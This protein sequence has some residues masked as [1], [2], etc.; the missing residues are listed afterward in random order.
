MSFPNF[1]HEDIL[2]YL[3]KSDKAGFW[4]IVFVV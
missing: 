1:L 2:P 4:K 3:L